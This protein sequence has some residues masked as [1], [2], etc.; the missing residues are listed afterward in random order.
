[1]KGTNIPDK[2]STR[3][4]KWSKTELKEI[5]RAAKGAHEKVIRVE[6]ECGL[7][8]GKL[9]QAVRAIIEGETVAKEA[10]ANWSR[11]I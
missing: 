2:A 9:R 6:T 4:R 11:Q 8:S 7:S 1:M 5:E 10:R 3:N